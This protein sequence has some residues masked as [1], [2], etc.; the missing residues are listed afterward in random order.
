MLMEIIDPETGK[1]VP[2]GE[3]GELVITHLNAEG[4]VLVRYRTHDIAAL[5][6]PP[7]SCGAHFNKRLM[8]PSGRMDLQ[9]KVGNGYK[10]YPVLFDEAVYINSDVIDYHVEIT[11]EGYQDVLT[12]TI[13]TENPSEEL[14]EKLVESISGIMEISDGIGED[15][16]AVPRVQFEGRNNGDYATKVKKIKDLRENYD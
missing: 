15:L 4:T 7:C 12:F 5:L 6:D 9:F 1:H 16:V 10:V 3:K 13:E 2:P 8:K 14:R 11:R